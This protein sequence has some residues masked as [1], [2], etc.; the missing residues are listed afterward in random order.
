MEET[1]I[2]VKQLQKIEAFI[3]P[4]LERIAKLEQSVASKETEVIT[5]KLAFEN[6]NRTLEDVFK[7][8]KLQ[9]KSFFNRLS[10]LQ[11]AGLSGRI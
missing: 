3:N 2:N 11:I 9:P 7:V 1:E 4:Y 6:L 10:L 5:L 8:V